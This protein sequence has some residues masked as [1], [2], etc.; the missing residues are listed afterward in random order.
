MCSSTLAGGAKSWQG[1]ASSLRDGLSSKSS[2]SSKFISSS[3]FE[4]LPRRSLEAFLV[5]ETQLHASI[6]WVEE[7][8]TDASMAGLKIS[9][10][11][12]VEKRSWSVDWVLFRSTTT[13]LRPCLEIC[14]WY[15]LSSIVLVDNNR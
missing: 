9:L 1:L 8:H 10:S 13:P 4:K 7:R 11:W 3:P 6:L 14:L 5:A 2:S 12:S 15:I